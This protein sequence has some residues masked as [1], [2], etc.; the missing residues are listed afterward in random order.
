MLFRSWNGTT[1]QA[2]RTQIAAALGGGTTSRTWSYNFDPPTPS[3]LPYWVTVQSTDSTT[4]S[5]YAYINAF[6]IENA[7]APTVTVTTP[8]DNSTVTGP[9]TIS[10]SA[11]DNV[12]VTG[13]QVEIYDRD[14]TQWWNGTTWQTGRTQIA[15]ALGGGTTSRTWSY[16]FDPPTPSTLPYWVTVQSTD[17]TTLS[18]YA[19]INA[20]WIENATAPT[21]TVTTPA[22][23]STVTGPVTISG[24]ATDNVG[25]TGV[26]V[27]IYDRDTTQWWNGTTWQ[28]SRTTLAAALD[29]G[30]TSRTWSYTLILLHMVAGI[31]VH[32]FAYL[33][34]QKKIRRAILR[35][36]DHP[37]IWI[38]IL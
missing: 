12:G 25:V 36:G 16:T 27:E 13:V 31:E 8:A 29:P 7:T 22:D 10:G 37:L 26:Q 9:V 38:H 18:P 4:L 17:S 5:P 3:T 1:W 24:S 21:V 11:T 14:T 15:A 2:G 34:K 20:F 35:T 28:T 30:T 6:W 32:R 19:Y 33:H 23:N